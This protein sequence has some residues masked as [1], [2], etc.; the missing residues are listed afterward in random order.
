MAVTLRAQARGST[1]DSA[2]VWRGERGDHCGADVS[3][4][5]A[6]VLHEAHSRCMDCVRT[7]PST[8]D[9]FSDLAAAGFC[10]TSERAELCTQLEGWISPSRSV[11]PQRVQ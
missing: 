6:R 11:F 2:L 8:A 9:G 7:E 4:R 3:D 10:D 5:L 1:R